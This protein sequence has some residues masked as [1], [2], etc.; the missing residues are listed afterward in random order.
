MVLSNAS[1][2]V[3]ALLSSSSPSP[4]F[5]QQPCLPTQRKI[6]LPIHS[7]FEDP[8]EGASDSFASSQQVLIQF[9]S[10]TE[11]SFSQSAAEASS[12]PLQPASSSLACKSAL[13]DLRRSNKPFS[14]PSPQVEQPAY[15][16]VG[17]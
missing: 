7:Q 14:Q 3:I 8:R 12:H 2:R 5:L 6:P 16:L 10:S 15:H 9:A 13:I 11:S 1:F 4:C 17:F